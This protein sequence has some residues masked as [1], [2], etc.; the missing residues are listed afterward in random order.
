MRGTSLQWY[1]SYLHNRQQFVKLNQDTSD[2]KIIACGVP[3]RSVLGP[4]LF[5][6]DINDIYFSA[7]DIFYLQMAPACFTPINHIVT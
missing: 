1:E 6:I 5:L 2:Q 7:P 3:Q 4:L